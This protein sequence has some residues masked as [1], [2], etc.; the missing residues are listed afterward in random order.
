MIQNIFVKLFLVTLV[1]I[2]AV[3]IA[4]PIN[5]CGCPRQNRPVCGSDGQDYDSECILKCVAKDQ[6]GLTLDVPYPCAE[7]RG[8]YE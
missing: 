6:P 7:K 3:S 4:Y 5:P 1:V 8:V 2:F